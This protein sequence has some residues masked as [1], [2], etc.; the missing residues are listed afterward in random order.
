MAKKSKVPGWIWPL[1]IAV[2]GA[3]SVATVLLRGCWHRKISWPVRHDDE[4]SYIVC[5][6][7]GIKRLFDENAFREFGPYGYEIEDLI[8][9]DRAK[10]AARRQRL[11]K[12]I[13][14]VPAAAIVEKERTTA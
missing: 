9:Q 14:P 4:Y 7:C 5:T 1:G 2:A 3:G 6:N 8:A 11:E 13:K 10:Q 12:K